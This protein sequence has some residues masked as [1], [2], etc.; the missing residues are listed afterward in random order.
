M[1]FSSAALAELLMSKW[2]INL[3]RSGLMLRHK[4]TPRIYDHYFK[5]ELV[6]FTQFLFL[7]LLASWSY[8]KK[9]LEMQLDR[10]EARRIMSFMNWLKCCP[11]LVQ[12][13]VNLTRRPSSALLSPI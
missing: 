2:K 3:S 7:L 5:A 8:E 4:W 6:E 10:E 11:Y 1:I 13:Q 9:N 12:L